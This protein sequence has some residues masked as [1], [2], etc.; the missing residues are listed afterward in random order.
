MTRCILLLTMTIVLMS[1]IGVFSPTASAESGPSDERAAMELALDDPFVQ[2]RLA[3]R[4]NLEPRATRAQVTGQPDARVW[5]VRWFE[6][7]APDDDP[8]LSATVNLDAES[9]EPAGQS[10]VIMPGRSTNA[11]A[12]LG[13]TTWW[14]SLVVAFG[15][16]V[17]GAT[18]RGVRLLL[19][20]AVASA[21]FVVVLLDVVP[22][23]DVRGWN[24]ALFGGTVAVLAVGSFLWIGAAAR[25]APPF[26]PRLPW[27]VWL[28]CLAVG[29]AF[30]VHGAASSVQP[31]DVAFASDIGARLTQGGVAPYGNIVDMPGVLIHGDTYGPVAYLAYV[32]GV[33]S[34]DQG[35]QGVLW[36]NVA[37]VLGVAMTLIL[38]GRHRGNPRAG[39][40]AAATWTTCPPVAIGAIAGNNDVVVAAALTALLLCVR[41]PAW[42]GA[43][44]AIAACTKFLPIVLGI[45]LLRLRGETRR[46]T[47]RFI[48]GGAGTMVLL[49]FVSFRGLEPA[50]DFW[51]RA[52]LYQLDRDD[53]ASVWGLTGRS[54]AR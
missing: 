5:I 25:P 2:D 28:A 11:E 49:F 54:D 24:V 29:A 10:L 7:D 50:R 53:I 3:L 15:L 13:S 4:P 48:A 45:L 46:D 16:C 44:L 17:A 9:V 23:D 30:I 52:I 47:A 8:K 36:T 34:V 42:R 41:R 37:L 43:T 35:V 19:P 21:I 39:L 12:W 40:W 32:P 18:G 51:D 26:R 6:Q 38:V 33:A 27:P 1:V 31:I 14:V 22:R 20:L